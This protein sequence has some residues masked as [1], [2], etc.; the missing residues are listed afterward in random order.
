MTPVANGSRARA[1]QGLPMAEFSLTPVGSAA[2]P[3]LDVI[4]VHGLG[5][6]PAK[7]WTN[8]DGVFWPKWLL[9]LPGVAVW[10]LACPADKTRWSQDG[11][12]LDE[13]IAV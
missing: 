7:M 2:D 13:A 11:R 5:S 1:G 4:F 9:D 6:D 12:R 10:S 8:D 3:V